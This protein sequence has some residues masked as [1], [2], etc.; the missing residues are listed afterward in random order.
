[1]RKFLGTLVIVVAAIAALGWMRGWFDIATVSEES[2]TNIELRI[3]KDKIKQD[4]EAAKEKAREIASPSGSE[5]G[6]PAGLSD[7]EP[8]EIPDTP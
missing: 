1:M 5:T 6:E 2:E 7:S 8:S 3:D 4:A